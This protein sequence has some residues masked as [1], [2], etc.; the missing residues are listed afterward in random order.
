[1]LKNLSFPG[2]QKLGP[3]HKDKAEKNSY[4]REKELVQLDRVTTRGFF[5]MGLEEKLS[6]CRCFVGSSIA[7]STPFIVLLSPQYLVI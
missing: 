4:R 3:S 2:V 6:S 1:M 5:S 7:A